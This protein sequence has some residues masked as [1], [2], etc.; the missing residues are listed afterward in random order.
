MKEKRERDLTMRSSS[1][2]KLKEGFSFLKKIQ[3]VRFLAKHSHVQGV[4][5]GEG[6]GSLAHVQAGVSTPAQEYR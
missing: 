2:N 4:G 6:A 3:S 1:K 5:A